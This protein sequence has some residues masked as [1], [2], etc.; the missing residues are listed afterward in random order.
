[1]AFGFDDKYVDID[2]TRDIV[3]NIGDIRLS[4]SGF[5]GE[6]LNSDN[7][8]F[9]DERIADDESAQQSVGTIQGATVCAVSPAAGRPDTSTA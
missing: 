4:V 8:I 2:L 7:F 6:D 5:G 1:M 3:R 9:D